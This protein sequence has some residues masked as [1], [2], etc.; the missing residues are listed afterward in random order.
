MMVTRKSIKG[1][2]RYYD[3]FPFTL[4]YSKSKGGS[5]GLKGQN[6]LT[7]TWR[8]TTI[9]SLIYDSL[10]LYPFP[11]GD[12]KDR[13][14]IICRPAGENHDGVIHLESRS[15][16]VYLTTKKTDYSKDNL[17]QAPCP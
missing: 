2:D 11:I 1:E 5:S 14:F 9:F 4:I 13:P 6:H 7:E 16:S 17:F 15:Y 8:L 12:F 10:H 3:Y